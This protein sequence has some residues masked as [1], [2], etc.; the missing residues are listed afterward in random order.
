MRVLFSQWIEK[1]VR[2]TLTLAVITIIM[3]FY[4]S[5]IAPGYL[6]EEGE[7]SILIRI[8]YKGAFETDI[9]RL[10]SEPLERELSKITG[11]KELF[12][13]SEQ[14]KA[15]IHLSFYPESD[16]AAC[17]MKV[18]E[19]V[20][21]VHASFPPGVQR[22]VIIKS[23]IKDRP[24]FIAAFDKEE[25]PDEDHVRRIFENIDGA[26]EIEIGG[27]FKKEVQL[28][29]SLEKLSARQ[30]AII[31][32]VGSL[33]Q[34][35][36]TG[37]FGKETSIPAI[38]DGRLKTLEQIRELPIT[39]YIRCGDCATVTLQDAEQESIGRV[40][41]KEKMIVYVNRAG[42]AQTV[43][44]CRRLEALVKQLP[45]G[46]IIYNYG[47]KIEQSLLEIAILTF[48]GAVL[49][50]ILIITFLKKIYAAFLVS[51][52]IPFSIVFTLCILRLTGNELTVM[53]LCGIAIGVGLVIDA[54]VVF[55]EEFF[56][57][58]GNMEK[59]LGSI[60]APV[61]FASATTIAVF[62]PLL[63]A[64]RK[65]MDQFGSLSI[66][67]TAS[68]AGSLLFVFLFLP[69]YLM[70]A[71]KKS[72]N[73][74]TG[75]VKKREEKKKKVFVNL[76]FY[77]A[78]KK[79]VTLLIIIVAL[80]S[81]LCIMMQMQ[82]E[83]FE[84]GTEDTL[85]LTLEFKSGTTIHHIIEKASLLET[86]ITSQNE[87]TTTSAK[88]EKERATFTMTLC[89]GTK[90]ESIINK[91][92]TRQPD[93][94]DAFFYFPEK[95]ARTDSFEIILTGSNQAVLKECSVMIASR[96]QSITPVENIIFHYKDVLPAKLI[97]IEPVS[98]AR[99]RCNPYNIYTT[100]Y[101]ALSTPV[102][103]KWNP[104]RQETDIRIVTD[105]SSNATEKVI[106]GL[107]VKD[108]S[109]NTIE[110]KNCVTIKE[111]PEHGR[112]YHYNR[113]RSVSFSIEMEKRYKQEVFRTVQEILRSFPFPRGY[114][115]EVGLKERE[116]NQIYLS[117]IISLMLSLVLI[118]LILVF[119]FESPVIPLLIIIQIPL[120]FIFPVYLLALL[121]FSL[122][123][124]VMIGLILTAGISVNNSILVFEKV[125]Y[126]TLTT[127][128]L[129]TGLKK[130]MRAAL[131]ASLTTIIG[132]LPL[133]F[134]GRGER[135]ILSPLSLTVAAGLAG[136]LFF[137]VLSLAFFGKR[138]K[139]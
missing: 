108:N 7:K 131:I 63:F 52:N 86:F 127:F 121:G 74:N 68:I 132:V 50:S 139:R 6:P 76:F 122:T 70:L 5:G 44:L 95:T 113:Q 21:Y 54:G 97:N 93:I 72:I 77:F 60:T 11:I 24:V 119:Q 79:P 116:Q 110:L 17:Y 104:E 78:H 56:S 12:S 42:D 94:P 128:A 64:E 47:K 16:F 80:F 31:D 115:G 32:V 14:S 134:S 99:L 103:S 124:P 137:L 87:V 10:I 66:A 40:N 126:K 73:S 2:V 123:L 102:A 4:A 39:P 30:L 89:K 38:I 67:V 34:N 26:G 105:I 22:P 28:H 48:T 117:G 45:G 33:R 101:W 125:R 53:T 61:L 46:D 114:R 57:M 29:L 111:K 130:K 129:F 69:A 82:H 135:G 100:I 18:R 90:K 136:S 118:F 49:V 107:P 20:D 91:I 59:T 23:D 27:G 133:L 58:Q 13:V 85:S 3:V 9:E 92:K 112:I 96:I 109:G 55:V 84:A 15:R 83:S 65:L 106:M 75:H 81:S 98:A 19:V 43:L 25:A 35:N 71:Y 1:P 36:L 8:E 51:M 41:G 62:A 88:F 37:S 120:S 138:M